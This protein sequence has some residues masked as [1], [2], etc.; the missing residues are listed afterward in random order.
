[1]LVAKRSAD[2]NE[3]ILQV[4]DRVGQQMHDYGLRDDYQTPRGAVS[5]VG[6]DSLIVLDTRVLRAIDL[7]TSR[8]E[9]LGPC[10][11]DR[12]V[13]VNG[14]RGLV[15]VDDSGVLRY[16]DPFTGRVQP[17]GAWGS[18]AIRA[19]AQFGDL[20]AVSGF[21]KQVLVFS[22][23]SGMRWELPGDGGPVS[24]VEF[25]PRG[26][27]LYTASSQRVRVWTLPLPPDMFS[28]PRGDVLT[29]LRDRTNIGVQRN[30]TASSGY[31]LT[32]K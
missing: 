26:R 10:E 20:V 12:G 5:F 15:F 13:F 30:E 32:W 18:G 31:D 7:D 16:M 21:W 22:L 11:A 29:Y 24:R 17:L 25:D 1:M 2:S 28:I 3:V 4:Y 23:S 8:E 9:M 27:W 6:S 14:G 19:A